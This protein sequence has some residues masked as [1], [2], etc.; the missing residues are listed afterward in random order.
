VPLSRITKK[1][2]VNLMKFLDGWGVASDRFQMSIFPCNNIRKHANRLKIAANYHFCI[3]PDFATVTVHLSKGSF[4]QK[5][6]VSVRVRFSV[7]LRNLRKYSLD[8]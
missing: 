7:K 6:R 5:V 8:K 2:S 1:L 4:V 3:S